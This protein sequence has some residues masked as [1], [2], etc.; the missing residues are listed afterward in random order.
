MVAEEG[1]VVV[2]GWASGGG[3]VIG[4]KEVAEKVYSQSRRFMKYHLLM[5]VL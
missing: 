1:K 2:V 5:A 4:S 3:A